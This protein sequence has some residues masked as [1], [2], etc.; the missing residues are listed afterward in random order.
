[1]IALVVRRCSL[2]VQT[3]AW[4]EDGSKIESSKAEAKKR[5]REEGH[6]WSS[7]ERQLSAP[8]FTFFGLSVL[9]L[10]D[11]F[12]WARLTTPV[13]LFPVWQCASAKSVVWNLEGPERQN[14]Q[15]L[16]VSPRQLDDT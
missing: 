1:M 3:A 13:L 14:N 11:S 5:T 15:S 7:A 10:F 16:E 2:P 4:A 9:W 8:A 12:D 6:N